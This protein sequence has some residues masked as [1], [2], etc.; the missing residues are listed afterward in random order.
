[1]MGFHV[2]ELTNQNY[3]FSNFATCKSYADQ[4]YMHLQQVKRG[5]K[6]I[7]YFILYRDQRR[8]LYIRLE[9]SSYLDRHTFLA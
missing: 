9:S 4:N 1:M 8:P 5:E 7:K 6:Y 2:H 3:L